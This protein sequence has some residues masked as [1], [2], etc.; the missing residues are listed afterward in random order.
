MQNTQ[1]AGNGKI[2]LKSVICII[3]MY[4]CIIMHYYALLCIIMH[5]YALLCIILHYYV[6]LC[7]IATVRM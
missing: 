2:E 4:L 6:L 1:I 5:Y 3:S 7:I